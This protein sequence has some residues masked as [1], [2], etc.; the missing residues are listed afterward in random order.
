M[1]RAAADRPLPWRCPK[2]LHKAVRPVAMPY[3]A[4]AS[5][6]G[7]LYELDIAEIQIP[8]CAACGELVFSNRVDEQIT[9]ALRTHLRLLTPEQIREARTR[10]GLQQKELAECLGATEQSL[11]RWEEG[12]LLQARVMDNLLRVYFALPEARSLLIGLNQDPN[13]GIATPH[14]RPG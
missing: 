8:R 14:A 11:M 10:L 13:L 12:T 7:R 1:K 6:D 9:L 5:H 2:C 3:H 4:R